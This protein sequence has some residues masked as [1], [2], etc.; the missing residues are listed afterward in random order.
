MAGCFISSGPVQKKCSVW[1]WDWYEVP[2]VAMT[3]PSGIW[4]HSDGLKWPRPVSCGATL[5]VLR[6]IKD[7]RGGAN[8]DRT[9]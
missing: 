6:R 7:V 3:P 1:G 8:E 5:V 4:P 2:G 9:V